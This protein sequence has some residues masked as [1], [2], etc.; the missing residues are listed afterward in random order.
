MFRLR[1]K[2]ER[3]KTETFWL[4]SYHTFSFAEYYDPLHMGFSDLRVINDD[5]VAPEGGFSFLRHDNMEIVSIVLSGTLEHKD[6]LGSGSLIHAGEIQKMTAG[7][8]IL[9]SE[10]NPSLSEPVHF[11]QIWILPDEKNLS[12]SYEQARLDEQ[13]MKNK[14]LTAVSPKNKEAPIHINQDV[15][16]C[17]AMLGLDKKIKYEINKHRKY[18]IQIAQGAIELNSGILAAGDGL[19]IAKEHGV[20]E[21]KGISEK[22]NIILF[23]MKE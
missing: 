15:E 3:G 5:I 7:T 1:P 8:G 17:Q 12:P 18:W 23:D 13:K 10:F 22:S 19:A 2:D 6:N 21:L 11:L 4:K 14:F 9:H 20:I 16:I